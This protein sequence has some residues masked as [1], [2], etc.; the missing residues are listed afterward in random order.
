M[1]ADSP[2]P[3]TRIS[4]T[5]NCVQF[6][7]HQFF[8]SINR[9]WYYQWWRLRRSQCPGLYHQSSWPSNILVALMS[10]SSYYLILLIIFG[11]SALTVGS[12]RFATY[13]Y[14]RYTYR[15]ISIYSL[16]I[17]SP[18]FLVNFEPYQTINVKTN[19][20]YAKVIRECVAR[21]QIFAKCQ[22]HLEQI[23]D[24]IVLWM[25]TTSAMIMCTLIYHTSVIIQNFTLIYN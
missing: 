16:V 21:H 3:P 25:L 24:P 19:D 18:K 6:C 15:Y 22:D 5:W 7:S 9:S 10:S 11:Q 4:K 23:Y 12:I 8:R 14:S 1:A 13:L 17:T 2:L 20:D